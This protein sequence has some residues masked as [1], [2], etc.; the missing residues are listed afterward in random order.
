MMACDVIPKIRVVCL[1]TLARYSPRRTQAGMVG[2]AVLLKTR[3]HDVICQRRSP[4]DCKDVG[5]EGLLDLICQGGA[6]S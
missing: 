5:N 3:D 4:S 6:E 1:G 2:L